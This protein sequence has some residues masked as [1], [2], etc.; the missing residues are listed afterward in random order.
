[1]L[2]ESIVETF[3]TTLASV[4]CV[5]CGVSSLDVKAGMY[6]GQSKIRNF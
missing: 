6:P 3:N 4:W 5:V 2:V 1:M